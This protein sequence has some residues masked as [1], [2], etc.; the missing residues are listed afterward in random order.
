MTD[1][2]SRNPVSEIAMRSAIVLVAVLATCACAQNV[3]K[4]P[5][6]EKQATPAAA[7]P[8]A[9]SSSAADASPQA[10]SGAAP[11]VAHDPRS[12][13][14]QVTAI[15]LSD[16]HWRLELRMRPWHTGGDG[17]AEVLLHNQARELAEQQGYRHYVVLSF[18]QGIESS[19][20]I[21]Q[22]WA[23]GEIELQEALPPMPREKP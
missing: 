4:D 6:E 1:I 21:A 10:G 13:N 23:R 14:W 5:S 2:V 9:T 17:E 12:P 22:R 18:V 7:A 20:P 3:T 15:K 8:P 11:Q 19:A 16:N